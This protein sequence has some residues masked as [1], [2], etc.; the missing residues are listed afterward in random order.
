MKRLLP[1]SGKTEYTLGWARVLLPS[2]LG[3]SSGNVE[4]VEEMP[5]IG[6]GLSNSPL[7]FY[8]SGSLVGYQSSAILI[9]DTGSAIVVPSNALANQNAADWIAQAMLETLLDVP[10]PIDFVALAREAA[11]ENAMLFS[12]MH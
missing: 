12:C 6:E 4:P 11:A 7:V 9:P 8:Q 2:A 3:A 10:Y 5:R 1:G